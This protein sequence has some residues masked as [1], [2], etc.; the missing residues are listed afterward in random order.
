LK[1]EADLAAGVAVYLASPAA[2][3]LS[4]R[5]MSANWDVDEL[6]AKKDEINQKNLLRIGL[7]GSFGVKQFL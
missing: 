5:Y 6:E 1:P 3:F 2:R 7:E 4:G